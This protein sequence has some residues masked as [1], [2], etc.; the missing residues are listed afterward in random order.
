MSRQS[1]VD[2]TEKGLYEIWIWCF[3]SAKS[4]LQGRRA[5]CPRRYRREENWHL[6]EVQVVGHPPRDVDDGVLRVLVAH[7]EVQAVRVALGSK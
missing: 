5:N 3:I 2:P 7:D 1:G 4:Y 6:R